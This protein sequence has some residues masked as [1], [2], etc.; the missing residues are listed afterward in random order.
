MRAAILLVWAGVSA[1][2]V[3]RPPGPVVLVLVLQAAICASYLILVVNRSD[4]TRPIEH[5]AVVLATAVWR[6]IDQLVID[7]TLDGIGHVVRGWSSL[8]RR[9]Q[10]GSVRI[11]AG[12]A[13]TAILVMIGYLLWR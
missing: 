4:A 11:H 10:A 9:A 7:N 8:L 5:R 12:A 1:G 2:L 3:A 6:A 13:L